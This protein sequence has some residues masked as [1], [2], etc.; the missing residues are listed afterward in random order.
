VKSEN[1][2]VRKQEDFLPSLFS[3]YFGV[4][5]VY[6]GPTGLIRSSITGC[7]LLEIDQDGVKELR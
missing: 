1:R 2:K 4:L 6:I 7:L 3:I 5:L